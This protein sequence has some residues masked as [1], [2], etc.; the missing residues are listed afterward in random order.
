MSKIR[1]PTS[2]N[3]KHITVNIPST[4]DNIDILSLSISQESEYSSELSNYG[5]L[6]G[7]IEN[8]GVG[9]PNVKVSVFVPITEQE[10]NDILFK[11]FYPFKNIEDKGY[12]GKRYNLLSR[13]KQ[14]GLL[15]AVNDFI[16]GFGKNVLGLGYKPETPV[17]SFWSKQETSLNNTLLEIYKSKY[18]YTATTNDSGDYCIVGVPVGTQ[19]IH[20]DLDLTDIGF[21]S[22]KPIVLSKLLNFPQTLFSK[23]GKIIKKQKNLDNSPHII[24]QQKVVNIIPFL[25]LENVNQENRQI[26]IS[27]CDFEIIAPITPTSTFFTSGFTMNK[28]SYWGDDVQVRIGI[29]LSAIQFKILGVD[30]SL[31]LPFPAIWIDFTSNRFQINGGKYKVPSFIVTYL[32]FIGLDRALNFNA[33][34]DSFA[35]ESDLP[36]FTSNFNDGANLFNHRIEEIEIDVLN[37]KEISQEVLNEIVNTE[38]LLTEDYGELVKKIYL[39]PQENYIVEKE[40]GTLCV[41]I[42]CDSDYFITN[43]YGEFIPSNKEGVGIP[44]S[45]RGSLHLTMTGDVIN[46]EGSFLVDKL[47]HKFPQYKN[48]S[49]PIVGRKNEMGEVLFNNK[50]NRWLINY[51]VFKLNRVYSTFQKLSIS[52]TLNTKKGNNTNPNDNNFSFDNI[53]S[54]VN[55]RSSDVENNYGI[56]ILYDNNTKEQMLTTGEYINFSVYFP[57]YSYSSNLGEFVPPGLTNDI[58]FN[59]LPLGAGKINSSHWS[60]S[61]ASTED[62][63]YYND[64]NTINP[65]PEDKYLFI[66]GFVDVPK[67]DVLTFY[68]HKKTNNGSVVK[69]DFTINE[70]VNLIGK[71]KLPYTNFEDFSSY[72]NTNVFNNQSNFVWFK[73][74]KE[75]DCF[76]FI[77]KNNLV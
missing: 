63:S 16:N 14:N 9:I 67:K 28:N 74:L 46:P 4:V 34:V 37:H 62:F 32:G 5:V 43:E 17:G 64:R 27:R 45:Y 77:V 50:I 71:Y 52:Y 44:T 76:S 41:I 15:N 25:G 18:K 60:L 22:M 65:N 7:R 48:T 8:N 23:N 61:Y 1:I 72:T 69:S 39:E 47:K 36:N 70:K 68:L 2:K 38:V 13:I 58:N 21:L 20:I 51:H 49:Y 66:N 53:G 54:I 30:V 6:V 10:E 35:K 57:Q 33:N 56:D 26:G 75:S 59:N 73:G 11:T 31:P 24:T 55:I 19:T 3:D 42:K 40:K 29:G 12:D